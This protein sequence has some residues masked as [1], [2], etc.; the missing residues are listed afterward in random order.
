M[1]LTSTTLDVTSHP[2]GPDPISVSVQIDK[3][4]RSL[5]F[6]S[7]EARAQDRLVFSAQGLFAR[8]T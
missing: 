6:V 7:C 5:A 2:L 3:R 4:A 1:R 8:Q